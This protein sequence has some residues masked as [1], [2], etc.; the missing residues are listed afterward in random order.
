MK[1]LFA[2]IIVL[3]FCCIPSYAQIWEGSGGN[4]IDEGLGF[5][6]GISGGGSSLVTYTV[7]FTGYDQSLW[8]GSTFTGVPKGLSLSVITPTP[9]AAGYIFTGWTTA[10]DYP[11]VITLPQKVNE[12]ATYL[13]LFQK[14]SYTLYYSLNGSTVHS[15]V[16]Y[17]GDEVIPYI[18]NI[19][20]GK[21][22]KWNDD[23]VTMPPATTTVTGISVDTFVHAFEIEQSN[24]FNINYLYDS[25]E[26][27]PIS[28]SN[29]GAASTISNWDNTSTSWKSFAESIIK[30]VM[31]NQNGT[32]AYDLDP[33]D[34]TLK[35]DGVTNSDL[36]SFA[37]GQATTANAMVQFKRLYKSAFY[38]YNTDKIIVAFSEYPLNHNFS[39]DAF[40]SEQGI[41]CENMYLGM[42][43]GYIYN[44]TL[45][46]IY[47]NAKPS[48]RYS[49]N[50]L[51]TAAEQNG[52][53]WGIESYA[54][55]DYVSML[56]MLF[57]K[58]VNLNTPYGTG[59]NVIPVN[60][61][62]NQY[63]NDIGITVSFPVFSRNETGGHPVKTL[64]LE[65]FWGNFA[66]YYI[67]LK[68]VGSDVYY[69]P[70][71]PFYN[72]TDDVSAYYK[73]PKTGSDYTMARTPFGILLPASI[74]NGKSLFGIYTYNWGLNSSYSYKR[75][76][77]GGWGTVGFF[78][79]GFATAN[80][81]NQITNSRL[82]YVK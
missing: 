20:S 81:G 14:Q 1:K 64:W 70:Y 23:P 21:Y 75:I 26:M 72:S 78:P 16:Y 43:E 10:S 79:S 4:H 62:T 46:S 8:S 69:K 57:S 38:N 34:Q 35:S 55:H 61:T 47:V 74:A 25:I 28:V 66:K 7:A 71:P 31:L 22:A 12:D 27:S 41:I 36:T 50:T 15:E 52:S 30:P 32:I 82:S 2:F 54:M 68:I 58:N 76:T 11:N 3:M 29:Y 24:S 19:S 5:D 6:N 49:A 63:C 39:A 80:T 67:G 9:S 45:R 73:I 17:Y 60:G 44:N 59:H 56:L 13:A 37:A 40:T 65:N 42:F 18:H 48:S 77:D 51:V 53:G 33:S